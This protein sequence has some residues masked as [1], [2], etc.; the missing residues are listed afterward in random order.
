MASIN[1]FARTMAL[2][3]GLGMTLTA[4]FLI[5]S[6]LQ[7]QPQFACK[8]PTSNIEI[9]FCLH[10]EYE[11]ADRRL[12]QTYQ[13]VIRSMGSERKDLLIDAQLAWIEFR[14]KGCEAEVFDSRGGTGFSG[15]L[16]EC[17]TRVTEARTA[18][19]NQ[20]RFR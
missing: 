1:T 7:A 9:K 3:G 4:P 15:F 5:P 14:D 6:S 10:Q 2:F 17:L 16:S 11:E 19:L 13:R 18:E 20:R 12:N 8:N